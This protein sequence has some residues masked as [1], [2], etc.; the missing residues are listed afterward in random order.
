M[1]RIAFVPACCLT[2]FAVS[3]C[4]ET[5]Q[6]TGAGVQGEVLLDLTAE[7]RIRP[8]S[9]SQT[10][11]SVIDNSV[12]PDD[13]TVE[14]FRTDSPDGDVRI[15]RESYADI[16]GQPIGLNGGR[17]R[18]YAYYGDPDAAALCLLWRSGRRR[19]RCMVLCCGAG[20]FHYGRATACEPV[21]CGEAFQC[22]RCGGVR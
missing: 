20:F 22:R 9:K 14:I 3:A 11:G 2:F 4:T 18:L 10:D 12:S 7:Q 15:F 16:K 19:F 1:R 13:F 17:F 21:R 5:L 8:V 6:E